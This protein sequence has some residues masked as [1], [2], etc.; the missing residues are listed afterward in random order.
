MPKKDPVESLNAV[1]SFLTE[2]GETMSH[3]SDGIRDEDEDEI[4]ECVE[5]L[6][7]KREITK[8]LTLLGHL[9]ETQPWKKGKKN[10]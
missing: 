1:S 3:L 6:P 5:S 2:L 7:T 10:A 4:K 8:N 9:L